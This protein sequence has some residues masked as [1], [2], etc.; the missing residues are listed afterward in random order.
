MEVFIVLWRESWIPTSYYVVNCQMIP[1]K[2]D[3]PDPLWGT[4][5]NWCSVESYAPTPPLSTQN[6]VITQDSKRLYYS[7]LLCCVLLFESHS[8]IPFTVILYAVFLCDVAQSTAHHI[9]TLIFT[10]SLGLR[11]SCHPQP[12][13][14]EN[15]VIFQDGHS[16]LSPF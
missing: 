3:T 15:K 9:I 2:N 5:G 16:G 14:W 10:Q 4:Q 8:S 7:T 1:Y 6:H 11:A 13:T 12:H